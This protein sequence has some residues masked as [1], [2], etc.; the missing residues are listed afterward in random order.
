MQKFAFRLED[1]LFALHERLREKSWIPDLYVCFP[2]ADPKPRLIHKASVRD[3]VLYQGVHRQV[4]PVF[5]RTFI[6]DSYASRVDKGVLAGVIRLE[7]FVR[8]ASQNYTRR[9]FVL[10]CDIR[11]FFDRIDHA[12]LMRLLQKKVT[13][14]KLLALLLQ[15]VSSFE[16]SPGK[17]LPL[18]NVTSQLFANVYLNELDQFVKRTLKQP[19]YI[20]YCDDFVI[21]GTNAE[22][23]QIL[24][25]K[26]SDFLEETLCLSLHPRKVSVRAL[27]HGADFL[28][29]VTFSGYKTLRTRT[30]QRMF[31]RCCGI[32]Q[33]RTT[34]AEEA[35]AGRVLI[36][37]KGLLSH[38]REY[39]TWK[40]L[41]R[42]YAWGNA[43]C[44]KEEYGYNCPV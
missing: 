35:Y 44:A 1:A 43:Y 11:K 32:F 27:H 24:I 16:K 39:R 36:S 41:E 34:D 38:S 29:Y 14:S 21:V 25:P 5:D 18:G 8:K 42:I 17:G 13:D 19:Y 22:E 7:E 12:V 31:K 26:I 6:H 37:Y 4:Y 23:L 10:K 40:R 20:R 28:G 30:K 33:N 9:V 15:V 2:V 3:R